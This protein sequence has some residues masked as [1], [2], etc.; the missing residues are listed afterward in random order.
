MLAGQDVLWA[1]IPFS[2]SIPLK[3]TGPDSAVTGQPVQV[4]VIDGD[5]GDPQN[6]ATVGGA[7]T[8]PDGRATLTFPN[9][10]IYRLKAEKPDTIRSNSLVLCVDPP[11]AAACTSSDSAPPVVE[12]GFGASD[13]DL[14]G[15]RLASRDGRSR[16]I[17]VSWGAQD[18]AGSGVAHYSVEVSDV[19]DGAGASQAEPEWRTLLDKSPSNGLHFRGESG[20]AYRFRITATDRALNSSSI[21]TDPVLIPVDD[22][23]RGILH[24]STRLESHAGGERVG[25]HRGARQRGR[26]DRPHALPRQ[27]GGADRAQAREGREAARDGRRQEPDAAPARPHRAPQRALGQPEVEVRVAH[28]APALARRRP[29]GDRCGGAVAMR[30]RRVILGGLVA[31]ALA[32]PPAAGAAAPKVQQLVVFRDGAAVQKTVGTRHASVAVRGRRCA[33]G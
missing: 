17:L 15:R 13:P 11:G 33:V 7:T 6:G 2:V 32:A 19:A 5:K 31:V 20:D 30:A 25:S 29:G 18:G 26:R 28:A 27:A 14:P 8:G 23:D 21:V 22:R 24:L 3:L 1:G 9:E 4:Q 10:G 12:S 16:T